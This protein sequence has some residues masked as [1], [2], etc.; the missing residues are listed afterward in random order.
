MILSNFYALS[1]SNPMYKIIF[2]LIGISNFFLL[3]F[4]NLIIL[5]K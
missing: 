1:G 2:E 5:K 4:F 3:N